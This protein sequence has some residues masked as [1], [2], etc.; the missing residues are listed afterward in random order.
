[1]EV[2]RDDDPS[3]CASA[4]TTVTIHNVNPVLDIWWQNDELH[5]IVSEQGPAVVAPDLQTITITWG[6]GTNTV[7]SNWLPGVEFV[8]PHTYP[9]ISADYNVQV[10]S[11]DDDTGS[12][13]EEEP[14]EV[15]VTNLTIYDG[16]GATEPVADEDG[17]GAVTVANLNDTDADGILDFEDHAFYAGIG[18]GV[19]ETRTG[20]DRH[21]RDEVD[22]MKLIVHKPDFYAGGPVTLIALPPSRVIFWGDSQKTTTID[23]DYDPDAGVATWQSW[24][25]GGDRTIWVELVGDSATVAD[26]EL[27]LTYADYKPDSVKATGVWAYQTAD[28]FD[29]VNW[30]DLAGTI[31][32]TQMDQP[33]Q[34]KVEE[35]GGTGLRD[36]MLMTDGS[37]NQV[38]ANVMAMR[39]T[40]TPANV[41][42][43]LPRVKFDI[44]RQKE[45]KYWRRSADGVVDDLPPGKYDELSWPQTWEVGNDDSHN[46]DES[47]AVLE[48]G[49]MFSI[50]DP[51]I[52]DLESPPPLPAEFWQYW[53]YLNFNEF[54]RVRFDSQRPTGADPDNPTVLIAD[55]S[56]SSSKIPWHSRVSATWL[57][58][59]KWGRMGAGIGDNKIGSGH[60]GNLNNVNDPRPQ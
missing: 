16:Q 24:G 44:T 7:I 34:A 10:R 28:I 39:F 6:D 37:G 9:A 51:R 14:V 50:D 55:G 33:L 8:R 53:H 21:G 26:I 18:N 20:A 3:D 45:L 48:G 1:M 38:I 13:T 19:K 32:R 15:R 4:S 25:A 5:G 31:W 58:P 46:S 47:A 60:L 12:D 54:V 35:Y 40:V 49:H 59:L 11:V 36:P 22:L 52:R 57:G 2:C 17:G 43:I 41:S 42:T 29:K 23:A 30:A 56:Q 27:K